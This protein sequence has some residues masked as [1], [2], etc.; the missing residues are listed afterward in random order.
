[1]GLDHDGLVGQVRSETGGVH[2]DGE[3]TRPVV[4]TGLQVTGV[5]GAAAH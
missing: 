3:V 5:T 1:M 2:S 4:T